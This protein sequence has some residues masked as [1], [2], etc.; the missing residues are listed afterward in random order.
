MH[1][2][3]ITIGSILVLVGVVGLG[4][5]A[6]IDLSPESA[7]LG[8]YATG[9]AVLLAGAALVAVPYSRRLAA[10]FCAALLVG[11]AISTLRLV[12][13]PDLAEA[14]AWRYQVAAIALAV[15]LV[16]RF[17]VWFRSRPATRTG[18]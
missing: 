18:P 14:G 11:F 13:S 12:F 6:T 7:R 10:G 5:A 9:A 17:W 16:A 15:L 8:F 1:A 4:L 3:A 2:A